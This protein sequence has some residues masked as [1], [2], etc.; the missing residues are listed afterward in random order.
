MDDGQIKN[1]DA[2][3]EMKLEFSTTPKN[4]GSYENNINHVCYQLKFIFANVSQ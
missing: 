2:P 4:A 1:V 3:N